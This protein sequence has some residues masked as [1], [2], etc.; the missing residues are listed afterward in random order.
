M[1]PF[2]KKIID[3]YTSGM[4]DI[5]Y[6][7]E[8]RD[9][10]IDGLIKRTIVSNYGRI[11]RYNKCYKKWRLIRPIFMHGGYVVVSLG[12][13]TCKIHQLVAKAFIIN[14]LN[15]V[16]INHKNAVK[17]DN[18]VDNLEWCTPYENNLHARLIGVNDLRGERNGRTNLKNEDI[19]FIRL[20][21]TRNKNNRISQKKL[22]LMYNLSVCS[23]SNII[24]R[25]TWKHI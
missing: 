24:R 6:D 15:R 16:H 12:N 17:H 8:W 19:L 18:R 9:V 3:E 2:N 7:E 1:K 13:K 4:P 22:A 23:I 25:K 10:N 14:P 5:L 20:N 11:A 21:S